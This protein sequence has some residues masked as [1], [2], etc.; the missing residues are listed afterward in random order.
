MEAALAIFRAVDDPVSERRFR[1]HLAALEEA[2]GL[3]ASDA[4]APG[5]G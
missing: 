3:S 4:D 5:R 1:A 2:P